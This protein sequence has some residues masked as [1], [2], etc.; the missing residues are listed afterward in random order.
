M[1][2]AIP[3][4]D[5]VLCAHFGHC[6]EF[7]LLEAD[8]ASGELSEVQYLTPPP[9]EPGL[10][11]RWLGEKGV[12]VVIAGGMGARAQQ[13]FDGRGI[14]VLIGAPSEQPAE[15]VR[16]YLTGQLQTGANLCDH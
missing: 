7:A 15:L 11:P 5:K 14:A 12:D 1:K 16:R 8:K 9:H 3:C 2:I 4:A 10:L 6:E 13:L